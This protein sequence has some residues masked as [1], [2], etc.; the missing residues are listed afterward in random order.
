MLK[1]SN[2]IM[3]MKH[4]YVLSEDV[5]KEIMALS[6]FCN[7]CLLITG[8]QVYCI[9]SALHGKPWPEKCCN[10]TEALSD[11]L[12]AITSRVDLFGKQCNGLLSSIWSWYDIGQNRSLMVPLDEEDT[13]PN[14]VIIISKLFVGIWKWDG[15]VV[16]RLDFQSEG[17]WFEPNNTGL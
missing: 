7:F 12:T 13:K 5:N 14:K 10:L 6:S 9:C 1:S 3:P 15:L 11:K 4:T 16:S 17:R 2:F 8:Q